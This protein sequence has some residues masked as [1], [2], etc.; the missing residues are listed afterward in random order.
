MPGVDMTLPCTAYTGDEPFAFVCYAHSDAEQVYPEIRR[1]DL[2]GYRIWYDEGISPGDEWP[3]EIANAVCKSKQF[4][5]FVTQRAIDSHNVRNEINYALKLRKPFLAVHLSET[6]LPAGMDLQMSSIQAILKW[7]IND[8]TFVRNL[9]RVREQYLT[10]S[11]VLLTMLHIAGF[12]VSRAED[13]DTDL[14]LSSDLVDLLAELEHDRWARRRT[15]AGWRYHPGRTDKD[16]RL[17]PFLVPWSQIPEKIRD[18]NRRTVEFL[19]ALLLKA[20]YSMTSI[21]E[22]PDRESLFQLERK[23]NDPGGE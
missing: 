7:R 15:E 1:L 19:P 8:Q 23:S 4:I 13:T 5:V 20:G 11:R 6:S 3:E 18:M 14:P 2:M 10:E 17:S 9:E 12:N 16:K 22:H 21:Y